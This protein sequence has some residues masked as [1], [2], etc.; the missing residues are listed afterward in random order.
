VSMICEASLQLVKWHGQQFASAKNR[1]TLF[2]LDLSKEV[3]LD[4]ETTLV[5][6]CDPKFVNNIRD[7]PQALQMSG[8]GGMM[9]ITQKADL[10]GLLPDHIKPAETWFSHKAITNLLSFKSLNDIYRITYNSKKDKAFIVHM[11]EYGMTD[12]RFVKHPSGLHI[13]ERPDG[14]TRSTF[15]QTVKENMKMFT[16]RQIKSATKARELYEMLRCPLQ[17]DFDTTLRTNSI[18]GCQVTIDDA[19][20]M[21]K[22]WGPSVIKLKG[23]STQQKTIRKLSCIVAVPQEFISAQKNVT[24]SVDFFFINKYVF[25][26]TVST[27]VCS[28]TTSHCSTQKVRHYW[29]FLKEVLL[30]YYRRGLRVTLVQA[31]L[32]FKP[33]KELIEQLPCIL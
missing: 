15:V 12:L 4:L 26:T 10:P 22:I 19:Q 16:E 1:G 6:F 31:D 3:L 30:I 8:N 24:V 29:N 23:N 32:E 27:N 5:L 21:W 9:R 20:V 13:L 28:T 14:K 7:F 25:L 33:I 11:R 17:L 2:G 18:K